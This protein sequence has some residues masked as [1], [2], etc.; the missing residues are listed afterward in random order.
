MCDK[1]EFTDT[2]DGQKYR[3]V[4][5]GE[6]VWMAENLNF[7]IDDSWCYGDDEANGKIYGRLYTWEAAKSACPVGWHLPSRAEW[8]KLVDYAGGDS[9][10]GKKLKS[11]SGWK[12]YKGKRVNGGDDN[13][14]FSALP[15]GNRLSDGSFYD[16]AG[17]SGFWWSRG[18]RDSGYAYSRGMGCYND[19]L[20]EGAGRK[21][22][23]FSVRCVRD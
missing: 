6:Q 8:Q 5:I 1:G 9:V 19:L 16:G 21:S 4:K 20:G 3:T 15:G 11:T 17:Y 2:R 10:V 23:A 14:G 12:A 7:K 18:E 22:S 13:F